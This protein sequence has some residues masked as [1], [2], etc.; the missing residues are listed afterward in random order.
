MRMFTGGAFSPR[1]RPGALAR[2]GAVLSA[3]QLGAFTVLVFISIVAAG[4]TNPFHWGETAV[5]IALTASAW[6]LADSYRG[7]PWLANVR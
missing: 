6:V 3:V 7:V 5:S 2:L 1:P 4:S